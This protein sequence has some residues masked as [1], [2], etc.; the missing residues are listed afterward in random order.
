MN[1]EAFYSAYTAGNIK[2]QQYDPT[3]PDFKGAFQIAEELGYVRDS[4]GW[5]AA[6]GGAAAWFFGGHTAWQPIATAPTDVEILAGWFDADADNIWYNRPVFFWSG[7]WFDS[8][9]EVMCSPT[10][11]MTYA[12]QPPKGN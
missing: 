12:K 5:Q 1:I 7:H 2:A 9:T 4:V 3:S 6:V 10:H 8:R 11:W